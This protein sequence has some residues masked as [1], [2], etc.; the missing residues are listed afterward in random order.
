MNHRDN[1]D[2]LRG[3]AAAAVVAHHY[4]AYTGLA[5]PW[6]SDVGGL[7]GVQMFFVLSG[8]LIAQSAARHDWR[9]YLVRRAF[10]IYPAYWVALVGVG[11]LVSGVSYWPWPADWSDRLL[12]LLAL[13]HL[14]P[15]ALRHD[16]LTVSWTLTSEW[17]WYLS[18]PLLVAL[19]A[20][21]RQGRAGRHFWAIALAVGLAGAVAWVWAA[22]HQLLDPL[23]AGEMKRAG[24]D[25]ISEFMR[26]AFIANAPPA[27]YCFFLLGAAVHRYEA[28]MVRVPSWVLVA[29]FLLLAVPAVH[30]NA[31]LGLAP[32]PVS[33]FGLTAFL[34]LLLRLPTIAWRWPHALGEM[35]Y[36]IYLLH[37][38]VIVIV[39]QRLHW[40]GA[41]AQAVSLAT[42]LAL[43][44]AVHLLVE[45][46]MNR[47]GRTIRFRRPALHA[48]G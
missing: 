1:L 44:A 43:A 34:I 32:S 13:G 23:Y 46:P 22:N 47:F 40:Q 16:V 9:T 42:L 5:L 14:T 26:F 19:A 25:P 45:R 11:V 3:L 6:L 2:P 21:W 17:A 36:P 18:A 8:Y 4:Q 7:L 10:R 48:H 27:Q 12:N 41:G 35:A 38:P 39:H 29:A 33:G 15:A 37:V 24:V 30:W 20:R 31:L 28:V